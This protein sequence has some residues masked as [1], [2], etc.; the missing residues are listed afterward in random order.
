MINNQIKNYDQKVFLN[1]SQPRL[2]VSNSE[3]QINAPN[4]D[5]ILDSSKMV[6][7]NDFQPGT[8][9]SPRNMFP[10]TD[11]EASVRGRTISVDFPSHP[12]STDVVK[13]NY[14]STS[15]RTDPN[16]KQDVHDSTRP[17]ILKEKL[18]EGS[19]GVVYKAAYCKMIA[20]TESKQIDHTKIEETSEMLAVKIMTNPVGSDSI[21]G[22]SI[23]PPI[24]MDIMARLRHENLIH[25]S[26][27]TIVDFITPTVTSMGSH[28]GTTLAISMPLAISNLM[29]YI[30]K[31]KLSLNTKISYIKQ[32]LSG[33]DYLHS[34]QILH[35]DLKL[36][37]ILV[38]TPSHV[39]ITDFG[40]SVYADASGRKIF[41]REAITITYR[42]PELFK[43]PHFYERSSD[44]WSFGMLC[45]YLMMNVKHIFSDVKPKSIRCKLAR[46][47]NDKN[48]KTTLNG[49]LRATIPEI[50]ERTVV[51]DFLDRLL[52]YRASDR[53][54]TKDL[55]NDPIFRLSKTTVSISKT[56]A[57]L[58]LYPLIWIYPPEK[59]GIETYLS[60]DFM[61]RLMININ[62]LAETF[63][64]GIDIFHR[65]LS[66]LYML[67]DHFKSSE[68][69]GKF[70]SEGSSLTEVISLGALT[71]VWIALKANDY[72]KWTAKSM[73]EITSGHYSPER[74][75]EME[76][77]IVIGLKGIIYRWNP[78][79]E[80]K[81]LDELSVLFE[82]VT[83]IYRYPHRV[84]NR[85][86]L[87][88]YS[89]DVLHQINFSYI[90]NKSLF[91]KESLQMTPEI[92]MQY[93][94][95][96]DR[97]EYFHSQ[98]KTTVSILGPPTLIVH[99]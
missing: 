98:I 75:L 41:Q 71:S 3:N 48:R 68:G 30:E 10:R 70:L 53:A 83:N 35:L 1:P 62:P 63:F 84:P 21:S 28:P 47:M 42:P 51:I 73:A 32:I 14:P 8:I 40:L 57:G 29:D 56:P 31:E 78:F 74:I 4:L 67:Y 64:I 87:L 85:N 2:I 45:L 36:E 16:L 66:H 44:V 38:L 27:I 65:S 89:I 20:I 61:I 86:K 34:E 33:L 69:T 11:G 22:S 82:T 60:I 72:K 76:R 26:Q 93:R 5:G 92:H 25:M 90:Y 12:P 54:T 99:N 24:E 43:D 6:T 49:Y 46:E 94:F 77:H 79:K 58:S 17:F 9:I 97:T 96:R 91:Y 18:A 15:P 80:A 55:L 39:V 37:N 7:N 88:F 81:T 50:G 59:I 52:S 19:Y 23:G 13:P 95:N